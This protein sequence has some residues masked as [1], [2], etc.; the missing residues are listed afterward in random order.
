MTSG[1]NQSPTTKP[2]GSRLPVPI[3]GNSRIKTNKPTNGV[4]HS[5][6]IHTA[7]EALAKVALEAVVVSAKATMEEVKAA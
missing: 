3:G 2:G 1:A 4:N 6:K 5:K 7:L